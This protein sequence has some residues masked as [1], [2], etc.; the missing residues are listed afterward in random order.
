MFLLQQYSTEAEITEWKEFIK[1]QA[2]DQ[3]A[4]EEAQRAGAVLYE[5]NENKVFVPAVEL[6]LSTKVYAIPQKATVTSFQILTHIG[7]VAAIK[8][9][10]VTNSVD[11]KLLEHSNKIFIR[12]I[13]T[14]F[15]LFTKEDT[16][17]Y[18][19]NYSD[20]TKK[21]TAT[22]K[23][24]AESMN[25]YV[26]YIKAAT[27]SAEWQD[28]SEKY[29]GYLGALNATGFNHTKEKY[30]D[31]S[32]KYLTLVDAINQLDKVI[33]STLTRF[34]S[35][36]SV[37]DAE[38]EN[39]QSNLA[40]DKRP[41]NIREAALADAIV[42]HDADIGQIETLATN[43][44]NIDF[45]NANSDTSENSLGNIKFTAQSLTNMIKIL[46]KI[47][48]AHRNINDSYD[49][50]P[51]TLKDTETLVQNIQ[52]NNADIGNIESVDG[53]NLKFDK[54]VAPSDDATTGK[55]TIESA[56][57]AIKA[58][59]N[60]IGT[61]TIIT[62]L[63]EVGNNNKLG[64]D[65]ATDL[66]NAISILKGYIGTINDL[67]DEV[68]GVDQNNL[69]D[70]IEALNK[71]IG[72]TAGIHDIDNGNDKNNIDDTINPNLVLSINK[73]D[74]LIGSLSKI[75]A[76]D[77]TNEINRQNNIRNKDIVLTINKLD[78]L[79]GAIQALHNINDND[80]NNIRSNS[81][82]ETINKLDN[83]IGGLNKLNNTPNNLSEQND[84]KNL[85]TAI[86]KLDHIIGLWSSEGWH[87]SLKGSDSIDE[88]SF[89]D[90]VLYLRN[91]DQW[92]QKLQES[93]VN[94]GTFNTWIELINNL[95]ENMDILD[96]NITTLYEW[97]NNSDNTNSGCNSINLTWGT[98]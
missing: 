55:A 4:A 49:D 18:T 20:K 80:R 63:D 45:T 74:N 26:D 29:T 11:K 50:R 68:N 32:G 15:K 54:N 70:A 58:L 87:Q 69:V 12:R 46:D 6:S 91:V 5:E 13:T 94:I 57:D 43:L 3:A 71:I 31:A 41:I 97:I 39:K 61:L 84:R 73:L 36:A 47:I 37:A 72:D 25:S 83:L 92:L 17:D 64:R 62:N 75:H 21:F 59:D 19:Y 51:I 88:S 40:G 81:L 67:N 66:V 56:T 93:K 82:T 85:T 27:V 86:N 16:A 8:E 90:I 30:N 33:G 9:D 7:D 89:N 65:N 1:D 95:G 96:A 23:S 48:G 10:N 78:S 28:L 22:G 53:D 76:V 24:K 98:F 60:I 14:T 38:D 2:P 42:R 79:I 44:N 52:H 34:E 77:S 35:K